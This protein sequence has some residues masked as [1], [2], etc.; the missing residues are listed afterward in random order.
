M[1]CDLVHSQV[2]LRITAEVSMICARWL[3]VALLNDVKIL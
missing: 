1:G 2:M 3:L